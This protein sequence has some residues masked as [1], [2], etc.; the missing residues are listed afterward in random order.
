MVLVHAVKHFL[1]SEFP[2]LRRE[3]WSVRKH[4]QHW[5]FNLSNVSHNPDKRFVEKLKEKFGSSDS[6]MDDSCEYD[7]QKTILIL[8]PKGIAGRIGQVMTPHNTDLE[9]IIVETEK[10]PI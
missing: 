5:T 10:I 1:L 6:P 7:P 2:E 4:N 3:K 9:V 8:A